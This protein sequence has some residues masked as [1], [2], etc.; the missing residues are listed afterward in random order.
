MI[1]TK[2]MKKEEVI[3]K[4]K[5]NMDEIRKFGVKRIGIF[6][7]VARD[8]ADENSDIDFVVEFYENRGGMEDFVGII[9]FLESIF[10]KKVDVLTPGGIENIR[11]KSIKNKIKRE[12]EYV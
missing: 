2:I 6:G 8:E 7:S 12:L 10:G 11:I 3:K 9:D 1:Y 4:L 5:E